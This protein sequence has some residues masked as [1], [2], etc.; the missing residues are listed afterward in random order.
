[1][2]EAVKNFG[3]VEKCAES[4]AQLRVQCMGSPI[5]HAIENMLDA[6]EAV[7]RGVDLSTQSFHK[8]GEW[9]SIGTV[10]K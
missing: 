1:M 8:W 4:L 9:K 3:S 2:N 5:F 10:E 6:N 7:D